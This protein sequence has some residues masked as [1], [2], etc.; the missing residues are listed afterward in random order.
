MVAS[1]PSREDVAV[2]PAAAAPHVTALLKL[3]MQTVF[4]HLPHAMAGDVERTRSM[5][6]AARRLRVALPLLASRPEG[7]RVA[8]AVKRLRQLIDA[9]GGSRDL[10]VAV[11]LLDQALARGSSPE[12][13]VL[14]R[15]LRA[16]RGRARRRMAETL[17]DIEIASL[18]RDLRAV[19]RRPADPIFAVLAR[20]R[21]VRE[22]LGE[23]MLGRFSAL[24]DDYEPEGL[25]RLRTR[26]RRLRYTVEA[27]EGLKAREAPTP[28]LFKTLQDD[29]GLVHDAHV[30]ATWLSRQA[31]ASRRRKT[32]EIAAEAA[33]LSAALREESREHHRVFLASR[34]AQA[35]T[36]AL[37][38]LGRPLSAA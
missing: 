37:A 31:A 10:D 9:A 4:R 17:L 1:R 27:R 26:L 36:A 25:H 2:P 34:P 8:R 13:Q 5:R 21:G 6:V 12:A 3:R 33:R 35:L 14:R 38:T 32:P 30:L 23:E 24:G 16:A 15:R 7:R 20:L 22:T 18:R 29:L 11:V 19:V 28:A